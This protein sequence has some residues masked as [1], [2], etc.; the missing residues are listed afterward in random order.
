MKYLVTGA[1]GFLGTNL[2]LRLLA[3]G[4]E[5]VGMDNLSTGTS[6][7]LKK[8]QMENGFS[9]IRHDVVMPYPKKAGEADFIYN[10]ACPASPPRYQRDPLQTFRTSV[11][12]VWNA[13]E[14][15]RANN[16]P[17]L[18][19]ST[20]EVYG[21]PLVHPQHE[22]YWGNV[23]PI[24]VRACYDEGKRGAEALL[25]DYFRA[26][27]KPVKIVRIFNTYGPHMDQ[28]DGRVISNFVI[29]ALLGEK[30][31]IYGDGQQTRSFCYVEDLVD[32][33]VRMEKSPVDFLGPVNLGNPDEFTILELASAVEEVLDTKLHIEF[34]PLPKDDPTKRQPDISLAKKKLGW[35]P[36]V[37]LKDG[38][39]KT[40]AYFKETLANEERK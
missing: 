34:L 39:V 19:T 8:L 10:L 6:S 33:L 23:N 40:V 31:T 25:A 5:V 13:T 1:A 32:G 16:I 21:D 2:C 15:A 7:N 38:L 3:E 14:C 12:G 37:M 22:G 29:Q 17:L 18:H 27:E 28:D 11:W 26:T 4:H 24:G 36:K 35:F 9:F 20:S 30:L